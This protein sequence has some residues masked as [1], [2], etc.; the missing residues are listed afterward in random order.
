[1]IEQRVMRPAFLRPSVFWQIFF[2]RSGTRARQGFQALPSELRVIV[3]AKAVREFL[4]ERPRHRRVAF[5]FG[6][7]RTPIQRGG[8][9][10]GIRIERDLV[11]ETL[12]CLIGSALPEA[13]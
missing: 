10:R 12:T 5:F 4:I 6:E 11:F 9:L 7:T 1:M 3:V 8:N 13:Q 2:R